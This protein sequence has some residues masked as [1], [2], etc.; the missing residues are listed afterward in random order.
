VKKAALQGRYQS[1]FA[2]FQ[3][4]IDRI[5]DGLDSEHE[6]EMSSLLTWNFQMFDDTP[7]L[8]A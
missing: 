2:G 1:D 8:T 6:T 5:L 7:I 3:T 4:A